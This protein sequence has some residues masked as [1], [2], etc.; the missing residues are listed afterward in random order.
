MK[1]DPAFR[2]N[3]DFGR[4]AVNVLVGVIWQTALVAMPIYVV[5]RDKTSALTCLSTVL[6]TGFFLK[7][8]WYE[9]MDRTEAP[10][11]SARPIAEVASKV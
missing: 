9:K 11:G 10:V 4:D 8:N 1:D 5:I 2:P 7:K 6:I 3:R